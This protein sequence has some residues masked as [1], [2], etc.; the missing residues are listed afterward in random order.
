MLQGR[1]QG[2]ARIRAHH[3]EGR[4]ADLAAQAVQVHQAP[5]RQ[6][7]IDSMGKRS[8]PCLVA[9]SATSATSATSAL[10][11]KLGLPICLH[12]CV[13]KMV[14]SSLQPRAVW[15]MWKERSH[16][17][18]CAH[19]LPAAAE[20]ELSVQPG[21]L[22]LGI[23][24]H[25]LR[26]LNQLST[27]PLCCSTWWKRRPSAYRSSSPDGYM[28]GAWN[29]SAL[30]GESSIWCKWAGILCGG[31]IESARQQSPG[32]EVMHAKICTVHLSGRQS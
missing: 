15:L 26:P 4:L 16:V 2:T 21:Q 17:S 8:E 3:P 31:C 30:S 10:P 28:V 24:L 11:D 14:T 18:R 22:S 32:H 5:R 12:M 9:I 27:P 7:G 13:G 23:L 25:R 29:M 6:S 1:Y 19:C 20:W